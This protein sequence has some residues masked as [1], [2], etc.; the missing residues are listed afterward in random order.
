MQK[1]LITLETLFVNQKTTVFGFQKSDIPTLLFVRS[2]MDAES[3]MV[4]RRIRKDVW[5]PGLTSRSHSTSVSTVRT[6]VRPGF[7]RHFRRPAATRR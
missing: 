6:G 7:A 4:R 1:T 5:G 3:L 2:C